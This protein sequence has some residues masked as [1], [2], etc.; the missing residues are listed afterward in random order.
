M[1]QT[2]L[3]T[4]ASSGLGAEMARQFAVLGH[5]LAL[6][7][8]RTDRLDELRAEILERHPERRIELSALDVTD[9]AAVFAVFRDFAGAFPRIDRV[10]VNA[11][12]G[13]GAPLGTGQFEANRETALTNFVGA[14]AQVEAAMEVFRAQGGGHLVAVASMSALRGMPKSM[15][16][17]AAT[18]AGLAHLVEGL[19]TEFYGKPGFDFTVLYPGYIASEMNAGVTAAENKMMVP[20]EK[21]VAEMVT[22]IEKKRASACVPRMPWAPVSVLMKHAPLPVFRKMI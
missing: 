12:L 2:I 1:T 17:Y 15:T 5:D 21:G 8:R 11:G 6:C 3:I 19:R 7:A 18:K 10:V 9:H 4:G 14:L 13:A 22:A 20:T 16:T